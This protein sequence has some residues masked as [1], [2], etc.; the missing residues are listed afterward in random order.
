MNTD[1][2]ESIKTKKAETFVSAFH[3]YTTLTYSRTNIL[4]YSKVYRIYKTAKSFKVERT[5]KISNL[6][7]QELKQFKQL[8]LQPNNI[9]FPIHKVTH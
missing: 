7:M 5:E 2:Q 9:D 6:L 8:N 3:Q 1:I 4:I